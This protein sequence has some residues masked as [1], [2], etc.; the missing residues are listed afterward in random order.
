MELTVDED[1]S[2][3][4]VSSRLVVSVLCV[5]SFAKRPDRPRREHSGRGDQ[6]ERSSTDAIAEEGSL[7]RGKRRSKGEGRKNEV[8][9]SSS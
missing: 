7:G 2:Q 6:E 1:E 4:S 8:R 3:D 5:E 9:V